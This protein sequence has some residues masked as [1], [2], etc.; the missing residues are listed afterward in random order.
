MVHTLQRTYSTCNIC[1]PFLKAGCGFVATF[2]FNYTKK[3][4]AVRN[5]H[6]TSQL[7]IPVV[8]T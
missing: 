3:L 8:I 5:M 4:H 1:Q 7:S 2:K 6:S